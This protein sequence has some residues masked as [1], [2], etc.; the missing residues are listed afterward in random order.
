MP[1]V[2]KSLVVALA[3]ILL[4]ACQSSAEPTQAGSAPSAPTSSA[5]D[6]TSA[7]LGNPLNPSAAPVGMWRDIPIMPQATAGEEAEGMYGYKV[8]AAP[9][10]VEDYYRKYLPPFKWVE[11]YY[12]PYQD[13]MGILMFSRGSSLLTIAI[14]DVNDYLLVLLNVQSQ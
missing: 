11:S 10:E 12:E 2:R 14:S 7:P 4:T 6:S 1:D 5:N 3:L 9:E 13:G 8:D